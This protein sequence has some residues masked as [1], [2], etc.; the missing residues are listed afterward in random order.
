[1]LSSPL[2]PNLKDSWTDLPNAPALLR[3]L[4]KVMAR[5]FN[6]TLRVAVGLTL[7]DFTVPKADRLQAEGFKSVEG[8]MLPPC[9]DRPL[10]VAVLALDSEM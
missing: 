5:Q 6:H 3:A 7:D 10:L 4:H 9:V 2:A 1:M 8:I